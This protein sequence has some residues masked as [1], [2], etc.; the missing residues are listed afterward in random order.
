[1]SKY[2]TEQYL[3]AEIQIK[4]E[5]LSFFK[6]DSELTIFDIG[7]CEGLDTIKYSRLFPNSK[8]YCFEPIPSNFELIKTNLESSNIKNANPFQIALSDKIG[9]AEFHLSSGEPEGKETEDWRFGN[10]SS[11][12]LPPKK[13]KEVVP[14]LKFENTINIPTD[15]IFNFCRKN[16][17]DRID[18]IHMDVQG[19]ELM[20][21]KGAEDLLSRIGMIWLEVEAI[22]LY[23]GQPLKSEVE[24]FM[25]K[26]GFSKWEDTVNNIA[27][28]Q[29]YVNQKLITPIHKFKKLIKSF[30]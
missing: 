4:K 11:S 16:N 19:A 30:F 29:L 8:I 21:L 20:V 10:K 18:F 9:Q 13:T 2:S 12:L 22:E 28:D 7:C 25:Q 3:K 17:L 23:D 15:T 6:T 5:L 26:N 24:K 1:M 14:W 27:G